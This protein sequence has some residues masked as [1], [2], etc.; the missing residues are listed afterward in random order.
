MILKYVCL[1]AFNNKRKILRRALAPGRQPT[2]LLSTFSVV[3]ANRVVVALAATTITVFVVLS[4]ERL[5][6]LVDELVEE[7]GE[8]GRTEG[9]HRVQVHSLPR[10]EAEVQEGSHLDADSD[11]WVHHRAVGRNCVFAATGDITC[12][13]GACS[14]VRGR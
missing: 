5:R 2:P 4:K 7:D 10:V 12:K 11:R 6:L 8:E 13:H 1:N 3:L 9:H 14:N